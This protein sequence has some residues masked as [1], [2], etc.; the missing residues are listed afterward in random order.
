MTNLLQKMDEE[1]GWLKAGFLGFAGSGKT[2]TAT[3]LAC[4]L[5]KHFNID[6]PMA[7]FDTE[8]GAVYVKKMVR[9]LTGQDIVGL[10]SRCFQDLLNVTKEIDK[11]GIQILLVDSV[12]HIWRELCDAW[13]KKINEQR[14]DRN[15]SPRSRLEFQDWG[16]LKKNGENGRTGIS[17]PNAMS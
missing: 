8:G 16:G 14:R 2:Y 7:M 1:Q 11:S 17:I 4:L 3:L 9:T 13:L 10:R 12:T 15:Q 6:K 5:K